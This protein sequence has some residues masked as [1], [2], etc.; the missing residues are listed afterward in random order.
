MTIQT[1]LFS[2]SNC[3]SKCDPIGSIMQGLLKSIIVKYL[4]NFLLFFLFRFERLAREL[5]KIVEQ[6]RNK[7]RA[8]GTAV[9]W[10]VDLMKPSA[11][12][13]TAYSPSVS[14]TVRARLSELNVAKIFKNKQNIVY[15]ANRAS[16]PPLPVACFI[17]CGM[18][19]RARIRTS[20][21]SFFR[22]YIFFIGDSFLL[23]LGLL[24]TYDGP[25]YAMCY[26][27]VVINIRW[28]VEKDLAVWI[29][30]EC[31][32]VATKL[33]LFASRRFRHTILLMYKLNLFRLFFFFLH[34]T[35]LFL[36]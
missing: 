12:D 5:W 4:W 23:F 30:R 1:G 33:S 24:S 35:F 10:K 34:W 22:F 14:S 18:S 21:Q 17:V 29:N 25:S 31:V 7:G 28:T 3:D 6:Q 15:H 9:I 26:D 27:I 2:I 20:S 19:A 11:A 16:F 32:F 13:K 36:S 8:K